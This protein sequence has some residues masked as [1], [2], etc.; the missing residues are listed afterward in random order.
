VKKGEGLG[1]GQVL[2][3]RCFDT[4]VAA[5]ML[6]GTGWLLALLLYLSR[7]ST[8]GPGLYRQVRVGRDGTTFEILKVRTMRLTADES[9]VTVAGDPR[10]TRLGAFLRRT[11]LDELP[12]LFNTLVGDMSLVGPRPEDPGYV[13]GY[14]PEQRQ[15][16]CVKPGITSAATVRH[17]HEE[18]L[19]TGPE[20]E[21]LYRTEVLPEKLRIELDYLSRRTFGTDLLILAQTASALFTKP[22][23]HGAHRGSQCRT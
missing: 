7:R 1:R 17:R 15:V 4:V 12:Q 21:T 14:S 10:V 2:R 8:G 9:A 20:W 19:L 23:R 13:A 11:K 6:L 18:E 5:T 22:S 16:L 3:K